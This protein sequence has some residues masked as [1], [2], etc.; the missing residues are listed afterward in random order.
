MYFICLQEAELAAL[1]TKV[2]AMSGSEPRLQ[3]IEARLGSMEERLSGLVRGAAEGGLVC[4]EEVVQVHTAISRQL[5]TLLDGLGD[6]RATPSKA[7]AS[8]HE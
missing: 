2:S 8:G 6:G 7:A 1:E 3:V 5:A 4:E